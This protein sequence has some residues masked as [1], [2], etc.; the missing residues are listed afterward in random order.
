M[1]NKG[2]RLIGQNFTGGGSSGSKHG[3]VGLAGIPKT[4]NLREGVPVLRK[5]SVGTANKAGLM[6]FVKV[7][8]QVYSRKWDMVESSPKK[9]TKSHSSA[10][11]TPA[12][13]SGWFL[14]PGE[15]TGI[16]KAHN[17]VG[18]NPSTSNMFYL[19]YGRAF[20]VQ[21]GTF[22][23]Q[24]IN[25]SV[26]PYD[27]NDTLSLSY[28]DTYFYVWNDSDVQEVN[29]SSRLAFPDADANNRYEAESIY[30]RILAWKTF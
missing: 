26:Q 21:P 19:L 13:N 4:S 29:Y 2:E 1:R 5:V 14:M 3:P 12:Y 17:M 16:T 8:G 18:I 7:N 25:S 10:L 9:F 22:Q 28:D 23:Y 20:V 27:G 11:G 24:L 30:L 6:E 15:D